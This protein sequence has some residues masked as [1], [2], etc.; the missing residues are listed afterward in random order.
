M[1][2]ISSAWF[3]RPC[4]EP[5]HSKEPIGGARVVQIKLLALGLGIKSLLN[6]EFKSDEHLLILMVVH[7]GDFG[8]ESA[9]TIKRDG[10]L[11]HIGD[12]FE[13]L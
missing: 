2:R 12:L 10:A 11:V 9:P 4:F 1:T 3:Y 5:K 7:V 8:D 6:S 13:P